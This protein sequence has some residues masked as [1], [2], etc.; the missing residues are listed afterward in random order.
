[1]NHPSLYLFLLFLS[2]TACQSKEKDN[3]LQLSESELQELEENGFIT[4]QTFEEIAP[5]LE[6]ESDYTYVINFWATWCKPC[7]EEMPYLETLHENFKDE[8]VKVVLVSLDFKKDIDKKFRSFLKERDLE[9]TVALLLDS[10]YNDWIDRVSPEWDGAIPATIVYNKDKKIFY[11]EQFSDY[12][13]LEA[14]VQSV[15]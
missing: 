12:Q 14:L 6:L 15:R 8:Q 11:G 4:Y 10:K 3:P 5:I 7:I 2:V 9:P 13:E 1:M